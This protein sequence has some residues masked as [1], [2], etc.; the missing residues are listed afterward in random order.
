MRTTALLLLLLL[1]GGCATT[2]GHKP[3]S[4]PPGDQ[5]PLEAAPPPPTMQPVQP[6]DPGRP[7]KPAPTPPGPAPAPLPQQP[8]PPGIP[9]D[10]ARQIPPLAPAQVRV[11]RA[12]GATAV[13][14][15]GTGGDLDRYEVYCKTAIE[16]GWQLIGSVP[17]RADNTGAYRWLDSRPAGSVA[18][19]YGVAAVNTLGAR[20]EITSAP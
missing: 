14:W 7:L 8:A 5:P 1:L 18:C 13:T 3:A 20:S 12:D 15:E 16:G 17:A 2:P 11:T 6:A 4:P 19:T 10:E 9:L